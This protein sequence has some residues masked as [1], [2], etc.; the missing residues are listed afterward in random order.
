[1]ARPQQFH[2]DIEVDDVAPAEQ[3]VRAQGAS[4]LDGGAG[5]GNVSAAPA[6]HPSCLIPQPPL[7]APN[8]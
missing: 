7:V 5:T 6:G 1:M 4:R 2:L 3:K 8:G